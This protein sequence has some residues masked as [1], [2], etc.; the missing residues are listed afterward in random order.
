MAAVDPAR[1]LVDLRASLRP[2]WQASFAAATRYVLATLTRDRLTRLIE[3][4]DEAAIL[5]VLDHSAAFLSLEVADSYEAAGAAT[6]RFLDRALD[7]GVAKAE[8]ELGVRFDV[9]NHG[10]VSSI[11]ANKVRLIREYTQGQRDAVKAAMEPG[12]EAGLNPRTQAIRF[13]DSVSLT[14]RQTAAVGKFRSLLETGSPQAL[15]RRL[16]DRRFDSTIQHAID[17]KQ[18]LTTAQID[19]MVGRYRERYIKYRSEVISRTEALRSANEGSHQM[20]QQAI[21]DGSL[22]PEGVVRT[23]LSTGD[24]RTRGSHSAAN[25]Q[26]RGLQEPFLVGSGALLQ[27]PGD[28]SGPPEETIQCRCT[29]TTRIEDTKP[30]SKPA[31]DHGADGVERIASDPAACPPGFVQKHW[32][33]WL[34]KGVAPAIVFTILKACVEYQEFGL[35]RPRTGGGRDGA[36]AREAE[37]E[38]SFTK[39]KYHKLSD[40]RAARTLTPGTRSFLGG[41]Y[42]AYNKALRARRLTPEQ[43]RMHEEIHSD[44]RPLKVG[45]TVY[46][47]E[48]E[49]QPRHDVTPGEEFV[50]DQQPFSTSLRTSVAGDFG[51]EVLYQLRVPK[52]KR[53]VMSGV[54]TSER[55]ILMPIGTRA[56]VLE[57]IDQDPKTGVLGVPGYTR[58]KRII[59]MDVLKDD[60]E[61][62][63]EA[64]PAPR[65][66]RPKKPKVLPD[67]DGP[68]VYSHHDPVAGKPF[69]PLDADDL[70]FIQGVVASGKIEVGVGQGSKLHNIL[71]SKGFG[72]DIYDGGGV[73]ILAPPGKTVDDLLGKPPAPAAAPAPPP[74]VQAKPEVPPAAAPPAPKPAKPKPAP[75]APKTTGK[76]P[77][78]K[79]FVPLK[80]GTKAVAIV[81]SIVSTGKPPAGVSGKL[82]GNHLFD[83]WTKTGFGYEKTGD[84]FKIVP[85]PGLTVDDLLGKPPKP[86]PEVVDLPVPEPKVAPMPA[87]GP[88]PLKPVEGQGKIVGK[89]PTDVPVKSFKL[90]K[91]G[92]KGADLIHSITETGKAPKGWG[93]ALAAKHL[94]TIWQNTGI[95]FRKQGDVFELLFPQ[96]K[97]LGDFLAPDLPMAA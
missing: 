47:G 15:K 42:T 13:R 8:V 51:G 53:G 44:M 18:P 94:Y 69:T 5:A 31:P 30:T 93:T 56:R 55:E 49:L 41:G 33:A 45:R 27:Y 91:P 10:A 62:A 80:S 12:V 86:K 37:N 11:K 46:R 1:R 65:R 4:G 89:L 21:Q 26:R 28:P 85:P 88:S 16:R 79:P 43:M 59:I 90:V 58:P 20:Y 32:Q 39:D 22:N 35:I 6:G 61:V 66:R 7:A 64:A 84:T 50:F 75:K 63:L 2:G 25:G 23:W 95:G 68:K 70:E 83:V 67:D 38:A 34:E 24:E 17:H 82:A 60:V 54:Y 74:A 52:G 57:V 3:R 14:K 9:R 36:L 71:N 77:V 73:K 81:E 96:G 78:S 87:I 92:T 48:R 76:M 72:Y 97:T 40:Y 19:K 29:L